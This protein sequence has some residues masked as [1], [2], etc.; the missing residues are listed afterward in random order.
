MSTPAAPPVGEIPNPQDEEFYASYVLSYLLFLLCLREW[1][2]VL[3][4]DDRWGL[5]IL[6]VLL[7]GALI[8]S[9]YLQIKKIR[10]IHETV[11]SIFAGMVVGLI[12]R[13]SPG[14]VIREMLV[15][16]VQAANLRADWSRFLCRRGQ[17][18]SLP[19]GS[20]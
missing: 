4:A 13:L 15:S 1:W 3:R 2:I 12:I 19:V 18:A 5:C 16:H 9:Y 14:H 7:I 20:L 11:I 17:L 8:T 10:A 6:C